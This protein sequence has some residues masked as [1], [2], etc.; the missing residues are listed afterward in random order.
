MPDKTTY[1][2]KND[3]SELADLC[4]KIEQFGHSLGLQPKSLF[5]IHLAVEEHFT[6][7][8]SHGYTD[9]DEHW[10]TM[11]L[12]HKEGVVEVCMEDDGIP[13]NPLE[14]SAP[15]TECCLEERQI[16]GLGVHLAKRCVDRMDY[17]REGSKNILTLKKQI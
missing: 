5:E 8:I 15:D 12:S 9:K 4:Q 16:G 6:N 3:L 14:A 1:R 10:I 13:F 2:F 11:R 17:R 7:I